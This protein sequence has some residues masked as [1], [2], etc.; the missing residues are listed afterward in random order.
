MAQRQFRDTFIEVNR[1]QVTV[2][3]ASANAGA[4][5]TSAAQT[6]AGAAVGDIVVVSSQTGIATGYFSGVVS[7]ANSVVLFYTNNAAGTVDLASAVYN[8]VV[9]RPKF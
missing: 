4:I 9:L 5:A 2:D 1:A 6:I 3:F 8:V 7:A